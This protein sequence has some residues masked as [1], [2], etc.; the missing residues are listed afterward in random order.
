ML[1]EKHREEL[2]RAEKSKYF[3]GAAFAAVFLVS[4]LLIGPLIHELAHVVVL[5][6]MGCGFS[7]ELFTSLTGLYGRIQPGCAFNAVQAVSFYS[8]GYASTIVS[9]GFLAYWSERKVR[10]YEERALLY[11][12]GGLGLMASIMLSFGAE[13]DIHQLLRVLGMPS[14]FRFPVVI[15]IISGV[16]ASS[17]RLLEV[18]FDPSEGEDG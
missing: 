10:V 9:G 2:K 16:S 11:G 4:A 17:L 5:V 14:S 3:E 18:L 8:V 1:P 7:T 15:F 6:S 13:G 12:A